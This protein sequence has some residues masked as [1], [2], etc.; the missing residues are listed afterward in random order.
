M[1]SLTFISLGNDYE[2]FFLNS[3]YKMIYSE[4]TK[5]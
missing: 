1:E 3:D 4:I 5:N 2:S